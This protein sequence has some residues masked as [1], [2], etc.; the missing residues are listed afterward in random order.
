MSSMTMCIDTCV[1]HTSNTS[2]IRKPC[3]VLSI[4]KERNK[5]RNKEVPEI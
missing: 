2:S 5:E 4:N 3:L 1:D